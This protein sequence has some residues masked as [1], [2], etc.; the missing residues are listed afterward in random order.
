MKVINDTSII[1]SGPILIKNGYV[2]YRYV[3]RH[4]PE[5]VSP[6]VIHRENVKLRDMETWE[7]NNFYEGRYF[8]DREEAEEEFYNLV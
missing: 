8:A 5:E 6:Y 2:P 1:G 4:L 3:L 7:H